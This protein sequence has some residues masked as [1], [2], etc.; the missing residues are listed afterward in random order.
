MRIIY[1]DFS[2][3]YYRDIA[4]A[5]P[6]DRVEGKFVQIRK[7]ASEYLIFSPRE[8]T[9]YHADVVERF[10]KDRGIAGVYDSAHKRFDILDPEWTV[11]GGGKFEMDR[12]K[13]RIRLYDDSMAYG[14][15]DRKGLMEKILSLAV[16][17][18]YKGK[19]E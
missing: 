16:F 1:R 10:S 15:F 11:I 13:K 12:K 7:G 3:T 6:P 17:S 4:G 2:E 14:K 18:G 8:F 5:D 19:I 9:K